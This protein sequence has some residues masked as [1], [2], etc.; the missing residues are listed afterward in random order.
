[1]KVGGSKMIRYRPSLNHKRK[2]CRP[3]IGECCF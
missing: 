2:R 1:M 3:G